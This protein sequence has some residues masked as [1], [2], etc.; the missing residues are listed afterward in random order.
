[1]KRFITVALALMGA[2]FLYAAIDPFST[3]SGAL[4][5]ETA[6]SKKLVKFP[7]NAVA[8]S[9]TT[10]SGEVVQIRCGGRGSFCNSAAL[11][12]ATANSR[13]VEVWHDHN[14]VYQVHSGAVDLVNTSAINQ[15][16]WVSGLFAFVFFSLATVAWKKYKPNEERS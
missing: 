3:P 7:G 15:Q 12:D 5:K 2:A 11:I 13:P 1:M 16:R 4:K 10:E 6:T 8:M 14:R 9:F